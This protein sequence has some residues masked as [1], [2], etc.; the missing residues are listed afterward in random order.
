MSVDTLGKIRGY[1]NAS[2]ILNFIRQKYDSEAISTVEKSTY[3][4]LD[5][6]TYPFELNEHSD[7]SE[8]YYIESGFIYFTYN[9]E[10][11][12]LFY[13]YSN[14]NPYENMSYYINHGLKDMVLSETTSINLGNWG[15]S[16]K[17][18]TEII[19]HF[20]G[21]WIDEND[22][23]SEEFYPIEVNKDNTIKPVIYITKEELYEKFGGVV[24][25]KDYK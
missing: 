2:E 12:S 22:C 16:V 20:G 1:V 5:E 8:H 10:N 21:G 7:D 19:S 15:D 3:N 13:C 14:I 23:D 17:I 4:K 25:I 18:I 6:I 24:I 9:N 11:R